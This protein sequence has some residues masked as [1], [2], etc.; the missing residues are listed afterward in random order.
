MRTVLLS[1][2]LMFTSAI[3]L[4]M[5]YDTA[6]HGLRPLVVPTVIVLAL[7]SFGVVGALR[8]PPEE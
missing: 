2:T 1:V 8:H 3:A 6:R 4:L 7:F 5:I